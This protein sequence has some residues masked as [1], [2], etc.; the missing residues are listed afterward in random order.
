[1]F[2]SNPT[3]GEQ[4]TL[5]DGRIFEWDGVRWNLVES[6]GGGGGTPG[7][8][9]IAYVG[10]APPASPAEGQLWFDS[11]TIKLSIRWSGTWI[12]I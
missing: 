1:M 4:V 6:G 8:S 3:I 5:A 2:P 9:G 12:G 11:A 7:S 10:T